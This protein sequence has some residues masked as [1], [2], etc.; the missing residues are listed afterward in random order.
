MTSFPDRACNDVPTSLFFPPRRDTRQARKAAEI[1]AR[2][3]RR[4]E[5]AAWALPLVDA[6]MLSQCVVAGVYVPYQ[7]VTSAERAAARGAL[8]A[9]ASAAEDD[10]GV[11]EHGSGIAGAA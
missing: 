11:E 10:D 1:C 2:C 5:C 9:L 8:E 3:P 7:R 4:R 6:G